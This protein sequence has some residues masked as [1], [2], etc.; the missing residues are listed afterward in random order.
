MNTRGVA[1]NST[2]GLESCLFAS[3]VQAVFTPDKS[4][5]FYN[6]PSPFS[7]LQPQAHV[8]S[9]L[10]YLLKLESVVQKYFKATM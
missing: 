4:S 7:V 3:G 6:S 2:L 10:Q 9:I 8:S 5:Q 1:G